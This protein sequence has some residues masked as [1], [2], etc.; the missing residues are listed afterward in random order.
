MLESLVTK[1]AQYGMQTTTLGGICYY[2]AW[3]LQEHIV[4]CEFRKTHKLN[5]VKS[6]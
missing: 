5:W 2:Y 3:S 1:S 6:L 4:Y